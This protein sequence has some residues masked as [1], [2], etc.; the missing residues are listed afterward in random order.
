[1]YNTVLAISPYRPLVVS[2]QLKLVDQEDQGQSSAECYS[3]LRAPRCSNGGADF[4][5]GSAING[6][7]VPPSPLS[8]ATSSPHTRIT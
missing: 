1:M 6:G 7:M 2:S 3:V 5:R 4:G 8:P